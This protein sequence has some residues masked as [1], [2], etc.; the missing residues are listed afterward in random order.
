[1]CL[2]V[3]QAVYRQWCRLPCYSRLRLLYVLLFNCPRN[4]GYACCRCCSDFPAMRASSLLCGREKS[5]L[6]EGPAGAPVPLRSWVVSEARLQLCP[7][8]PKAW[9]LGALI[10]NAVVTNITAS[11]V[12][13]GRH[14]RR[15]LLL[16]QRGSSLESPSLPCGFTW[17]ACY[18]SQADTMSESLTDAA[19]AEIIQQIKDSFDRKSEIPVRDRRSGDWVIVVSCRAQDDREEDFMTEWLFLART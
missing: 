17:A 11:S 2:H 18:R 12:R 14:I 15:D 9:S 16:R 5:L 19:A 8:K 4:C 1:M 13:S 10:T 3:C 7:A 6:S